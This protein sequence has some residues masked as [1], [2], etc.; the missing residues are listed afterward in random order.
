MKPQ[1]ARYTIRQCPLQCGNVWSIKW[2]KAADSPGCRDCVLKPSYHLNRSI[3]NEMYLLLVYEKFT[4]LQAL[5]YYQN[6][7]VCTACQF[8]M[9]YKF[10]FLIF[11]QSFLHSNCNVSED[12]NTMMNILTK[13][14]EVTCL[15]CEVPFLMTCICFLQQ[16][17]IVSQKTD[18]FVD[19]VSSHGTLVHVVPRHFWYQTNRNYLPHHKLS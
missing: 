6:V 10:V 5:E 3:G 16:L 12:P 13:C 18:A 4:S 17:C 15:R 11:Y 2:S 9:E 14:E 8:L 7:Q 1:F 19:A